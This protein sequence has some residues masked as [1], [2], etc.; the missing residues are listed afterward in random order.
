ME[1]KQTILIT[2]GAG[3]IGSVLVRRAISKGFHVNVLDQAGGDE[4][5]DA[6]LVKFFRGSIADYKTIEESLDAVDYVIHLAGVS[7]GRAGKENPELTKK[8]NVDCL[9][10]LVELSQKAKIKRFIFASTMG[11]YGNKYDIPLTEDLPLNPID[12]YSESKALG[13]EI[14]KNEKS[15]GFFTTVSLR[16]AMVYGYSPRMRYD[17]IVNRLTLDALEKKQITITGGKQK[18]PQVYIEDLSN[19][20]LEFLSADESGVNGESFN[21]V[22]VNPAIEEIADAVRQKLPETKIEKLSARDN[23]DSFEVDGGKL[24]RIIKHAQQKTLDAGIKG[25]ISEHNT[26]KQ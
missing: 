19:I 23:E 13:E 1:K 11:V 25:I 21:V 9:K 22:G 12:P 3:Y 6:P 2:G 17:F 4:F 7:D 5:A 20:F 16:I 24:K 14:I 18:R 10:Q 8:T 26:K 15:D